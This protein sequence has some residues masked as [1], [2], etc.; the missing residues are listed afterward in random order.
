M[1]LCVFLAVTKQLLNFTGGQCWLGT[2]YCILELMTNGE[3]VCREETRTGN[4]LRIAGGQVRNSSSLESDLFLVSPLPTSLIMWDDR[5]LKL[6][7]VVF[8]TLFTSL[9]GSTL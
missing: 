9:Q 7:A 1:C 3:Q 5:S 6:V 4:T 8:V 2:I